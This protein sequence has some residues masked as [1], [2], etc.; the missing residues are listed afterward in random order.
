MPCKRVTSSEVQRDFRLQQGIMSKSIKHASKNNM[1]VFI[2]ILNV[3]IN[4]LM[5][6][7]VFDALKGTSGFINIISIIYFY[8]LK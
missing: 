8:A 5:L 4:F 1:N 6:H 7:F 3:F 2:S